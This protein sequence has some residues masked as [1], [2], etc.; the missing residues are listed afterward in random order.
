[1]PVVRRGMAFGCLFMLLVMPVVAEGPVKPD[2]AN[3]FYAMDT[4]FQR[5]G[6]SADQQLDLVKELGYAGIAW[7]EAAP[8]Q[9]V[10]T[11]EQVEKRGLRMFA[12]YCQATVTPDGKLT[13]SPQLPKLMEALKGRGTI[14]WLHIG[15]KGP[16]FESL[17]E[18]EPLVQSLRELADLAAKNDL[19]IAVYPHVGEWTAHFAD[20]TKLAKIVNHKRFGVTFNLCHCLAMG[21]E[22]KIPALLDDAR[23]VLFTVTINGADS[24]VKGGQWN[25]LIQTLDKGSYD[26]WI[27]LRKL[28]QMEFTGPIGFQGYGIKGDSRS[29]LAPTLEAWRKLSAATTKEKTEPDKPAS[30][31]DRKLE[32]W[33]IR[34]DNRLLQGPD[35]ALGTRALRFLEG[36]LSDIKVVVPEDKLKKLQSVVIVLDLSHGNLGPMQYHPSAGWLKAN[37]YSTDLAKCVHLPRA[38]DLPTRRNITEQPWVIL[39]E[40]AHAYHDQVLGFDEPRIKE[41]YEKFKR[42]GRGEKALLH[43]GKRVKHYALTNQMEFF[44]EMTEAYFGVNDFFP[45]NRAELKEAEPEIYELLTTVWES[46]VR[47]EK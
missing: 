46:P 20:A 38:A 41:A 5:P 37:G 2:L 36:K 44:A 29:I 3:P 31:S 23:S 42:S 7:T 11:A 18:K 27:V 12:L 22:E 47:K 30:H 21:D 40:L 16:A 17:T 13:H 15:G 34:V 26:T 28:K 14:I 45:F 39:H 10:A 9:V 25:R 43:N 24:G 8:A 19:R 4:A 6:L 33:T 1:M 35:E 32:G